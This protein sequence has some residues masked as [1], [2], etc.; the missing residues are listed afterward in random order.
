MT[1]A[2]SLVTEPKLLMLD[3]PSMGLSP[4][5]VESVFET[6]K[7]MNA[8][9]T[10]ILLVEQNALMALSIAHHGYVLQTGQIV[11]SDTAE[12]LRS[13]EMVQKAYLGVE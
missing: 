1:I 4:I 10:T 2:R 11:L 5:L 9:G 3:E 13:N 12:N 6:I 8:K 7:Q